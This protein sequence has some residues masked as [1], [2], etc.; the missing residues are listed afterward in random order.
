VTTR[1]IVFRQQ[2]APLRKR[3]VTGW[4]R[5]GEGLENDL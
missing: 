5:F 4:K 2:G 3:P 1:K